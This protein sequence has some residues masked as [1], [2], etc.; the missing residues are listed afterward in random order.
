MVTGPARADAGERERAVWRALEGVMD[1]EIPVVSVVDLGIV[2]AVDIRGEAT[3]ITITPTFTGCPALDVIR[4]EIHEAVRAA[5][6]VQVNVH[7]VNDPP[8]STDWLSEQARQNLRS[9]GLSPPKKHGGN[10][11]L[12]LEDPAECPYCGSFDTELKNRFG[13]TLCR[14]IH[15]CRSC[16]QPFESFKPL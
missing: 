12:V 8:W 3:T 7:V 13:S 1:P 11:D 4:E 15:I 5:G 10:I 6:F 2:R 14:S 9:F 16:R